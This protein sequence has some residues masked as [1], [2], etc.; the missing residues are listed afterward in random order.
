[1]GVAIRLENNSGEGI[2]DTLEFVC[3]I[4]RCTEENRIGVVKVRTNEG[5][6]D[7]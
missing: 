5:M 4:V 1:M 7:K 6:S 3:D 2:L